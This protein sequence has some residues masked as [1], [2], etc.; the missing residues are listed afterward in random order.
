MI[1]ELGYFSLTLAMVLSVLL[2][3]FPLW[4]AHTGNL[5][6]MR[7]A[8]SLAVGQ[9]VF[10]LLSFAA[11]I[12]ASLT[13]DF[14][15]SYVAYHSSSTL[16]WYYKITSTWG[17]HEGAIL[18][19]L[20][21]QAGWTA[22]VAMRSKSLPW[23]LRARVLGVLGFL[24][25][26]FMLYTLL[27]SSPFERLLPYFPVEGRDLN[28]LLQDP[29]MIIHPPLLY[30][31]Y[32]GLSVSFA[33]A[34]AALLTGKLDNTWAKWSRPW[35]MTAWGFLT[36]GITIGSWWAY[37]ELGWGGWWFW[38]PVENAS[39]MP[40]LVATALLHSLSTTEKRGVFKS[41]TVLLAIAAF[42]LSLLGT[43][44]VRSGIIVSVHA[45]ASDPNRGMFILA[46]LAI[47]VGGGLSLYALR[48]SQVKS[49]G[50]YKFASREVA[51]WLNN[52]F[53]VVATLI[54]LLGTL[55]PMIHKELGLGSISIGEPFFNK[56]FAILLVPFAILMGIGPLLR[57]KQNK[58]SMLQNKLALSAVVSVVATAAWLY[59]SYDVVAPITFIATTLAIWIF[60]TTF[61]DLVSK[62]TIHTTLSE[63]FKRLGLSYW[64]M[65]L[66]HVGLAFVIAGV[67]LTS[68]YSVERDV[69][70]KPGDKVALNEYQYRFDGVKAIR[71][72]NYSGHAGVVTVFKNDKQV[73]VL[74][75]EK[76]RYDIGM[77]FMTEAA[78]DA[79]FTRDLYLALGEQLSQGAW[80]LRIYHKPF[81]RWMWLG[82]ILISL[83][84]FLVLGDKRYRQK[85]L[86]GEAAA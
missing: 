68:A 50:R 71:G 73:T 10:V 76:R 46:F 26:G 55:L 58:W 27:M 74:H 84:G 52:I 28:P 41:W 6:L 36:F 77:Q 11:L 82:G 22:V 31:G 29:G 1:P 56:M 34:I 8:P 44:I 32:V 53:L 66:G 81:V 7:A 5:R 63:G 24:G 15:V 83:A 57:W 3:I 30:M 2:C 86:N 67:T 65:V 51:L 48:V 38:D 75:A 16:P 18:L 9:F 13:D 49:E 23:V 33:F 69:S 60:V 61:V 47:V 37:S 80:S 4:G 85:S 59:S 20:V 72:A 78:V 19:W 25:V 12:Y 79:G 62:V 21:M 35:T 45:F 17:G 70:M 39:L 43:F 14:T 40:W 64:A 42:S 54:V